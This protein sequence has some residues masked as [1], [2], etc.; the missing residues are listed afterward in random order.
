VATTTTDVSEVAGRLRLSVTR[1][2]RLLRQQG[3]T[4]L[5]P[6]QLSA[7]AAIEL[8]GPLTLGALAEHERVA[9]PTVT[10]AVAKLEE[11]GLV[12]R[13]ADPVDR[14]VARVTTTLAG[15]KLLREVR[16]RK[17]EWLATRIADLDATDRSRL[18]AAL[19]V[20]E[21]LTTKGTA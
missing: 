12:E 2:A 13:T 18:V 15:D 7:L 21:T 8:H 4:G 5:S 1:L 16:R 14:R 17:N 6:S 10:K 20:L 3:D 11:A 9:P 19:D